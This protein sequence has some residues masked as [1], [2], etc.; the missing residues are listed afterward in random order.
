MTLTDH[1]VCRFL[2]ERARALG[3]RKGPLFGRLKS[4][5]AVPGTGGRLVHPHEVRRQVP[6]GE[7]LVKFP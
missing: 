5:Q 3:V 4:G 1:S 6:V 2:P 7:T